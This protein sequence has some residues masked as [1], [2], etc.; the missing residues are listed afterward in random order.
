[1]RRKKDGKSTKNI[2]NSL[3]R[4][5]SLVSYS[6]IIPVKLKKKAKQQDSSSDSSNHEISL[7]DSSYLDSS[8][9]DEVPKD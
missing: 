4:P 3:P 6:G 1:M 9:S 8:W 7:N 2:K 5:S